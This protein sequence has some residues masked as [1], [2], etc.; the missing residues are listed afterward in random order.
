MNTYT[1]HKNKSARPRIMVWMGVFFVFMAFAGISLF[2]GQQNVQASLLQ[3]NQQTSEVFASLSGFEPGAKVDYRIV[4]RNVETFT[5]SA[6]VDD[7][8]T[9]DL[10]A[11]S[12]LETIQGKVRYHLEIGQGADKINVTFHFD[13]I[14]GKMSLE[15]ALGNEHESL[16]VTARQTVIKT[17]PDWAGLFEETGIRIPETISKEHPVQ[18]AFYN[19]DVGREGNNYQSPSY[20][21]VLTGPGGG[22][23]GS[24]NVNVWSETNCAPF[25]LSTCY[26]GRVNAQNDNIV[27]NIVH[28]M[29]LMTEQMTVVAMQQVVA[30]G[31]FFDAKDQMEA[32]REHQRLKAQAVK[33]YHPSGGRKHDGTNGPSGQMCRVGSFMKGLAE[34]EQK[35]KADHLALSTALTTSYT[36]VFNHGSAFGPESDFKNRLQQFKTTYCDPMDSDKGL[37]LLCDHDADGAGTGVGATNI[38]RV[39]KDVDFGRTIEFPYTLDIDFLNTDETDDEEDVIALGRNLYWPVAL[40]HVPAET[41]RDN[42]QYYQRARHLMAL[43]NLAHNSYTKLVAMKARAPVPDNAAAM[44]GWAHM[45]AMLREFGLTDPQI[46]EYYGE[47]PSYYSQMEILT[48]KTYQNPDFYT[49]LYDK[50]VNIERIHT[51]LNA[52]KL[53]QMR[54]QYEASLRRE[55]LAS[56]MIENELISDQE[57]LQGELLNAF[58]K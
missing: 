23:V 28:A 45:K 49:N 56:G 16:E 13:T 7:K 43:T 42:A 51:A 20:I 24:G 5:A 21:K 11:P 46:E 31:T 8:G 35:V 2:S 41:F 53:M 29:Q 44:P 38:R 34:T 36:N 27:N 15:G 50:P 57:V 10:P 48:K 37:E 25:Q 3:D 32:Q 54:D 26:T 1:R 9:L 30:V 19:N 39:N 17:K 14:N 55:M 52:I 22:Q 6:I 4:G 33:D 47:N 58:R 40:R 18:L 12:G